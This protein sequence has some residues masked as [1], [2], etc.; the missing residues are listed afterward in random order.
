MEPPA[1]Q[2]PKKLKK[3]GFNKNT[4]NPALPKV[5]QWLGFCLKMEGLIRGGTLPKSQQTQKSS[6]WGPEPLK[7]APGLPKLPKMMTFTSQNLENSHCKNE[8]KMKK[9]SKK[10]ANKKACH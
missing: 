8:P 3:K 5:G 2:N 1:T 10:E 9:L 6:K 7:G 4:K